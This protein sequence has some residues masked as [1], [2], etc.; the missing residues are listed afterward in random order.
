MWNKS[1]KIL[2]CASEFSWDIYTT[3]DWCCLLT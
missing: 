3:E 2:L 1:N